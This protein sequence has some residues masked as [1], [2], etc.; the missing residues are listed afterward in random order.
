[1]PW[2]PCSKCPA[3]FYLPKKRKGKNTKMH[4][5]HCVAC[6]AMGEEIRHVSREQVISARQELV[7][8]AKDMLRNCGR[9]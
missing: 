2:V 9:I 5:G 4:T 7:G 8:L 6:G 3:W 1:M